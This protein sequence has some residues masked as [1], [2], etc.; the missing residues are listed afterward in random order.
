MLFALLIIACGEVDG[1]LDWENSSSSSKPES[2]SSGTGSSSS[3][4]MDLE[5]VT[6]DGYKI[7][8]NLITQGQ[9]GLVMGINTEND[10][11]PIESVWF[12]AV[13]FCEKLSELMGF[14]IR[15][16]T[17]AEWENAALSDLIQREPVYYEWTSS[18]PRGSLD[19]PPDSEKVCKGNI[20]GD[21]YPVSPD[22]NDRPISFRVVRN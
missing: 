8:R 4:D 6:L 5:W 3:F 16:P 9:Y 10:V 2:S 14:A 21:S 19:C 13:R 18:C 12:D 11:L 7:S 20:I 22:W 17:E 1:T 15:L